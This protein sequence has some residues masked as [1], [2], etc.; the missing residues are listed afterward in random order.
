MN[1]TT[2]IATIES[3]KTKLSTLWIFIMFNMLFADIFTFMNPGFLKGLMGGFAEQVQITPGLLLGFAIVTE[4]SIAMVLLSRILSYRANRWANI[5]AGTITILY[6]IG[7]GSTTPHYIFFATI[8]V[9]AA[10]FIIWYA[11][12]W[13]SPQG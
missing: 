4:I 7:G 12:K 1:R 10:A 3:M 6:V 2:T 5:I 8:E 11:W 9:V 13:A